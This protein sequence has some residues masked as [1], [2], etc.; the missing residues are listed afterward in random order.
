MEADNVQ[1]NT[2]QP[3]FFRDIPV[4]YAVFRLIYDSTRTEVLNT[5]YTYVNEA[6]CQMAGHSMEEL[7]GHYFLDYYPD[8]SVWFPYCQEALEKKKTVHA[9]F[10]SKEAKHWLDFTVGPAAGQDTVVF[11]FVNVDKSIRKTR[12]ERATDNIILRISMILNSDE[13]FEDV[14][15]HALEELS[16]YIH[17]DRLYVLET[18]GHTASMSFEWCAEGISPEIQTLQNLDYDGYIG[19]WEK[20]LEKDSAVVIRDIKELKTD[21]PVD[22]ENLKRQGVRRVVAAPFYNRGK[23]IGYLGAD[24]YKR[25]DI[26]NTRM[27]LKT[28]S[29]YIGAKIV[30]HRL[31][32]D[33]NRLSHMDILTNVH[34]RNAMIE[35]TDALEERHVPVGIIYTDVNSLKLINDTQG[36]K[37]GDR[38]LQYSANMLAS[39]F[40]REHVFRAGGDEF[41]VIL[42]EIS[43]EDFQVQQEVLAQDLRKGN[44][45]QFSFGVCWCPDSG[46][47]EEAVRIADQHMYEAKALYYQ[48]SGKDRRKRGSFNA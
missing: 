13:A 47:I 42:P 27:V 2:A 44:P 32:E 20:Y 16:H 41:V 8:G 21:D 36:H 45:Y 9:C 46:R 1:Q 40:G 25:R 10:Y 11:V 3:D 23:L 30:N 34:N 19:G 6:Y 7:I 28:I 12:R 35:T 17:P 14:M 15:N 18:D 48:T 29:Y 33:L 43:E 4:P 38:A 22:Y 31:M 24:N 37:G 39:L 26:V 5:R